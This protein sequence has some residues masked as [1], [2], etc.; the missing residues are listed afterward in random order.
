M[1]G[2]TNSLSVAGGGLIAGALTGA[3]A[4]VHVPSPDNWAT[5]ALAAGA[6]GYA[7]L[8][9]YV[10]WKWPGAPPLPTLGQAAQV[11]ADAHPANDALGQ[12]AQ[13]LA[14]AHPQ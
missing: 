10:R 1:T 6:G 4:S 11:L 13:A 2:I 12:A 9:W 7:L 14:Q 8:A 5:L 3:L